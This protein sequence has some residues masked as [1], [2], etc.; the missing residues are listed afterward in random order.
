MILLLFQMR[1]QNNNFLKNTGFNLQYAGSTGFLNAGV[2]KRTASEKLEL[3]LMYGHTPKTFG[4]PLHSFTLKFLYSPW[5]I[6]FREVIFEPV[7]PGLFICQHFGKNVEVLWPRSQYP[8]GYYWWP[9]SLRRHLFVSSA[10]SFNTGFKEFR[11]AS[12]YFETNTNDLYL[13]SYLNK[14]NYNTLSFYDIIFFGLG[15]KVY[16]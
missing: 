13:F 3:G 15:V 5:Q 14:K 4:G 8:R 9:R 12:F 7:Q 11:R 2:G 10:V 16:R 1:S 6:K